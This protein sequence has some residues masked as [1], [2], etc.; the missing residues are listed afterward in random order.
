MNYC[1]VQRIHLCYIDILLGNKYIH[2][3]TLTPR[4]VYFKIKSGSWLYAAYDKFS[5]GP[6]SDR[7]RLHFDG[8]SY[9]GQLRKSNDIFSVWFLLYLF[10][11][12]YN[13]LKYSRG[14]VV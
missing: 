3:L 14:N 5:V 13:L 2:L 4:T 11:R 12:I 7:Y 10:V 8:K 1:S 6:E 9:R